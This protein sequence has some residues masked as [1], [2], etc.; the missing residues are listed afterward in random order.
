MN[1]PGGPKSRRASSPFVARQTR[2]TGPAET[3]QRP[4]GLNRASETA[5]KWPRNTKS[6]A[7]VRDVPQDHVVVPTGGDEALPGGRERRC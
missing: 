4:S 2:P 1:G 7:P 5:P 6:G 3:I